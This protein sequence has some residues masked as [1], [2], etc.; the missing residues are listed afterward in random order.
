MDQAV[1]FMLEIMRKT[2]VAENAK[3]PIIR[4]DNKK[5]AHRDIKMLK[6]YCKCHG[7]RFNDVVEKARCLVR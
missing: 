3:S 5:S 7:I 1:K 4:R 6:Y 2:K